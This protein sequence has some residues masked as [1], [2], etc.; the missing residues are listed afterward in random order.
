MP[1]GEIVKGPNTVHPEKPS[2]VGSRN[3]LNRSGRDEYLESQAIVDEE[4]DKLL[5][6]VSSKLPPEVLSKLEVMGGVKEKLHNYYNQSLQNMSNRYL[7]TVEDELSKKFRDLIDKEEHRGL[8]H[9]TPRAISEILEKIGGADKFNT[10]EIEKSIVNIFGH[11]QGSIQRG[12]FELEQETNSLLRQKTDVGA[13]VRGEN[14]YAI[15]KCSFKNNA[16][17]PRT[18]MDVKLAINILDSEFISQIHHYQEPI[19]N[20]LKGI[21]SD[22]IHILVDREI[23]ALNRSLIDEGKEELTS[24]EA[25]FEKFKALENYVED[26]KENENSRR[27]MFVAKKFMDSIDGIYSEI[28]PEGYDSLGVRE[29][30]KRIIDQENIRNRG[31][32]TAINLLTSTLDTSRMGY[33][34]IENFKNAR[35]CVIREYADTDIS[36]LPDERFEIHL[37][38]NDLSEIKELRKA[39]DIQMEEFQQ[40]IL[41]LWNVINVLHKDYKD[42]H[43]LQD[44][45]DIAEEYLSKKEELK[46]GW[47]SS[48]KD[49]EGEEE[50]EDDVLWNEL[51]F[52]ESTDNEVEQNNKTNKNFIMEL[53]QRLVF[54]KEQIAEIYKNQNPKERLIVDQ[55]INFLEMKFQEF[56]GKINPY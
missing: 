53:K 56:A 2:A 8:N 23:E 41:K 9:Y 16:D 43:N 20:L 22:H 36:S 54:L 48:D 26:D 10:G 32:N 13:F 45:D 35:Q 15:V 33:Q 25:I 21:I 55:R 14:A 11:L 24:N 40:E 30:I 49:E 42:K 29:N 37:L 17:K 4:V 44:F 34:H 19:L 50:K 39:Y 52:I 18:V 7:V 31:F 6:H 27:Y 28:D 3:S 5:N 1:H 12:V 46:K 47:F 51:V 38:Y